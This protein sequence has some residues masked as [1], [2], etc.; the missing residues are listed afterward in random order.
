MKTRTRMKLPGK[1]GI[2]VI[3]AVFWLV[4]ATVSLAQ[5]ITP[6]VGDLR[7]HRGTVTL[8]LRLN[9]EAYFLGIE[10]D[11][12][13]GI[14]AAA[15]SPDYR[16]LRALEPEVLRRRLIRAGQSWVPDVR[17]EVDGRDVLMTLT[18]VQVG[19]VGDITLPRISHITLT[20]SV[21]GD[22]GV[23]RVNWPDGAGTLVLRQQRAA[24]PFSG[25][26]DGGQSSPLIYVRGGEVRN[27]ETFKLFVQNGFLS[28]LPNGLDHVLFIL[29][30]FFLS[31]GLNALLWQAVAF[32]SAH[33]VTLALATLGL[34]SVPA[35]LAELL[36]AASIVY[37]AVGN[38]P[39]RDLSRMRL[40]AVFVFGLAHGVGLS[41]ALA[42]H[43]PLAVQTIPALLGFNAGVEIGQLAVLALAFFG[44]SYWFGAKPWYRS[45]VAVPISA[46]IAISGVYWLA[47]LVFY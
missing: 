6:V 17:I 45:Y 2:G 4:A 37:V 38:L 29:A 42:A 11:A 35:G 13:P 27:S 43:N 28:I 5:A 19:A 8:D 26:V 24:T 40:I 10:P 9:A 39:G 1:V 3:A 46:L 41:A 21:P 36:I 30:L 18:A 15:E 33:S 14:E 47:A 12:G 23:F 31:P 20:G 16:D 25:Y 34:I 22:A 44:V 7:I 32:T